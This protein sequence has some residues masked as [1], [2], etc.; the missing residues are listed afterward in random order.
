[1]QRRVN[2]TDYEIR[3]PRPE[4]QSGIVSVHVNSWITSYQNVLPEVYLKGDDFHER[5]AQR[6]K[7]VNELPGVKRVVVHRETGKVVGFGAAGPHRTAHPTFKGELYALYLIQEVHGH[8]LGTALLNVLTQWLS[9]YGLNSMSVWVLKN[10]QGAQKF[11]AK[12]G[13]EPVEEQIIQIGGV[14]YVEVCYGWKDLKQLADCDA[15]KRNRQQ[16]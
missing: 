10:N 16:A 12:S 11:Y 14:P 5:L 9:E 13:G 1:M 6:R 2:P 4:D 15:Q 8:G 7:Y 3:A